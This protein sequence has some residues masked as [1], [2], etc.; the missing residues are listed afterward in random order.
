VSPSR[1]ALRLLVS[2]GVIGILLWRVPVHEV[3]AAAARVH[4]A[5]LLGTIAIQALIF[6]LAALRW[7]MLFGACGLDG[8]PRFLRRYQAYWIG[9]F[10]NTWLPGGLGGDVVRAIATRH[11]VGGGGLPV[12][13][14]IILLE[15][16]LG[17]TAL[18]SLALTSAVLFPLPGLEAV[19]WWSGLGLG[20]ALGGLTGLMLVPQITRHLPATFARVAGAIPAVTSP[21]RLGTA[22]ALSTLVQLG[23]VAAAHL[24]MRNTGAQVT[25][26]DALTVL[27][28]ANAAVFFPFTF[29]GVGAREAAFVVLYGRIGVPAAAA[30][31]TA[32]VIT[33]LTY[34][35]GA[36]G[37]LLH[38]LAPLGGDP[39][40]GAN[41]GTSIPA[42]D[43]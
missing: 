13:L 17:V 35:I 8:R 39:E 33:A 4:P 31:A 38:L 3:A 23:S 9:D 14:G 43:R 40:P 41:D 34:I 28:L 42:P 1:V 37:G 26:R 2:A 22:F 7:G 32:L 11:A 24:V 36:I 30:L 19:R 21:G 29:A 27:P 18:L 6:A 15:R 25:W 16:V 12:A 10:Y 20:L 5:L